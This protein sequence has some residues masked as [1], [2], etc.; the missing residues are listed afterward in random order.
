MVAGIIAGMVVMG[1]MTERRSRATGEGIADAGFLRRPPSGW[2]EQ[3]EALLA[4]KLI[5]GISVVVTLA[6]YV[7]ENRF[8][9]GK[10]AAAHA[11][12]FRRK[13][14][15]L[16]PAERAFLSVLEQAMGDQGRV[17]CMVRVADVLD[18]D[19][20]SGE[21]EWRSALHQI[22]GAHFDFVICEPES[23]DVI[24]IVEL[25]D[26]SHARDAW[27]ERH[28]FLAEACTAAGLPV[29]QLPWQQSYDVAEIRA[30]VLSRLAG[31][32]LG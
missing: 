25:H 7:L 21:G 6:A 16:A 20:G 17:F 1:R 27:S 19:R 14:A 13:G 18:M 22:Q 4:T 29:I 24:C 11:P 31:A 8:R 15:L 10:P 12:A 5:V 30:L 26:A 32:A 23:T 9:R 3:G 2:G 28:A